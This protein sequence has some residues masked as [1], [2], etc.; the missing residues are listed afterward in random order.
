MKIFTFLATVILTFSQSGR[1]DHV[2]IAIAGGDEEIQAFEQNGVTYFSFSEFAEI[3]GG[4]LDWETVGQI[5]FYRI[6]TTRFDFLLESSYFKL[7]DSVFNMTYKAV[8]RDGQLYLPAQSFIP[9]LD[10]VISEKVSWD[11][12]KKLIRVDSEYF[13]VSD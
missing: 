2:N 11:K 3:I 7:G 13:N 9:F 12:E 6:D 1:A 10:N 5:V 4:M 8:Y